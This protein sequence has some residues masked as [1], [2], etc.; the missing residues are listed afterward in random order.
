MEPALENNVLYTNTPIL[1]EKE[2]LKEHDH[3]PH[4]SSPEEEKIPVKPMQI[5]QVNKEHIDH[6]LSAEETIFGF[7]GLK[8]YDE[9]NI[10]D[11]PIK[12]RGTQHIHTVRS[13]DSKSPPLV[14][15]HGYG[16]SSV[17]FYKMIRDLSHKFQVF[18]I[19]LLGMGLSSRPKF[20]LSGTEECITFFIDSIEEWR[21]ALKLENITLC[22][23][24]LGGYLSVN[25]TLKYRSAVKKLILMS[26]AGISG[27]D[28]VNFEEYLKHSGFMRRQFLKL[29]SKLWH[30]KYTPNKLY[31]KTGFLGR[32][33]L[34][35]YVTKRWSSTEAEAKPLQTYFDKILS[36]PE[37]SEAAL[38]SLLKLPRARAIIPM[39][40]YIRKELTKL[41][42]VFIYGD[43]DWM[44]C[45]GAIRLSKELPNVDFKRIRGAGHHANM[46]QP[47]E[48]CKI[49][50]G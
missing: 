42:I 31:Q 30:K 49:I 6:A 25:Y 50:M 15:I 34:K 16:G 38:H 17:T 4:I 26:P 23:H 48:V 45:S 8:V 47:K 24:S 35:L 11:V 3:F 1:L 27:L 29:A 19:D 32:Y 40:D 46:D 41:D 22:G 5:L 14:I 9:I 7:S 20:E 2:E 28:D 44:D 37:S 39:E 12:F 18:C 43:R 36:M 13:G 21:K 10:F 33:V